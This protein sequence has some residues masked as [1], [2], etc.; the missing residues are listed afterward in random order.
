MSLNLQPEEPKSSDYDMPPPPKAGFVLKTIGGFFASPFLLALTIP[1][2]SPI[3][4]FLFLI[5]AVVMLFFRETRPIALGAVLFL[6]VA[7]LLL[8]AICG[9]SHF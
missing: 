1:T 7:L 9:N 4:A 2:N 6:G 8:I 3:P 5:G